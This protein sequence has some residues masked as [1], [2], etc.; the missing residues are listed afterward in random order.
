MKNQNHLPPH[1]RVPTFVDLWARGLGVD[2]T[3][4]YQPQIQDAIEYGRL[5]LVNLC[6]AEAEK[7][8]DEISLKILSSLHFQMELMKEVIN[9]YRKKPAHDSRRYGQSDKD[10]VRL[11]HP[12]YNRSETIEI[13]MNS[14][15]KTIEDANKAAG[16]FKKL[17][18]NDD[19]LQWV[20]RRQN[21]DYVVFIAITTPRHGR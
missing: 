20:V 8:K 18:P 14:F 16:D 21:N 2:V 9:Y 3:I 7:K 1:P 17:E 4:F 11:G 6:K 15:H 12:N 5:D 13:Q 10:Q 19:N